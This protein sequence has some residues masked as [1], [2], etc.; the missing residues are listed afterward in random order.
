MTTNETRKITI[1]EYLAPETTVLDAHSAL[2]GLYPNPTPDRRDED[3]RNY[4]LV[5]KH[6]FDTDRR[7]SALRKELRRVKNRTFKEKLKDLFSK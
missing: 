7:L 5:Q 4:H 2:A 1:A 3:L 6:I